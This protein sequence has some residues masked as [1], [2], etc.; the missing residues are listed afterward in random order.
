MQGVKQLGGLYKRIPAP[1]RSFLVRA[2]IIFVLWQGLYQLVLAPARVP[3]KQ[4]TNATAFATAKTLSCI[5]KR[6]TFQYISP[7][8]SHD[9]VIFI[10]GLRWVSIADPCNGLD[11]FVL[12]TGFLFCFPATGRR[13]AIFLALGLPAIFAANILRC[14]VMAWI[15]LYHHSWIDISHHYIFTTVMYV[16]IFYVWVL[17]AKKPSYAVQS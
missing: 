3:D 5:W 11:L 17:Y 14:V 1:V 8:N 9:A 6:V 2:A 16:F 7:D 13:R 4:L 15:A 12:Y 10:R